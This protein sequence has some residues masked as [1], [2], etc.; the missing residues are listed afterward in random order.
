M[1]SSFE[2]Q[3][4]IKAKSQM[5]EEFNAISL[6]VKYSCKYLEFI[7]RTI[8]LIELSPLSRNA[9]RALPYND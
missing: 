1:F 2:L 8:Q 7:G 6:P 3:T 5:L 9:V 4:M